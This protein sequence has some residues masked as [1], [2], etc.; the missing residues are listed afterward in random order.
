[1]QP[2][3]P[4][5]QG[6]KFLRTWLNKLRAF[7]IAAQP[8]GSLSCDVHETPAGRAILP[9][10]SAEQQAAA[11][12]AQLRPFQLI[13]SEDESEAP[14]ILVVPSVI[15]NEEPENDQ[16]EQGRY[17]VIPSGTSGVV[18]GKVTDDVNYAIT[19]RML[20][21]LASVPADTDRIGFRPIGTYEIEDDVLTVANLLYGPIGHL[22]CAGSHVWWT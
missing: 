18:Y 6:P 13:A 9:I 10:G 5:K 8:L 1:M 17:I 12:A 21:P 2:P 19:E 4:I 15:H 22:N 14:I 7:A 3:P 16:D 20:V 11:A